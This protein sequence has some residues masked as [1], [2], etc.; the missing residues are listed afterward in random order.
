MALGPT[1]TPGLKVKNGLKM[2]LIRHSEKSRTSKLVEMANF[3]VSTA[4]F[5]HIH[6]FVLFRCIKYSWLVSG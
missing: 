6:L 1:E 4:L 5:L 2:V 3:G